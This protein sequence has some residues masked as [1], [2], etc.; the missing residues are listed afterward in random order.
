MK[1]L[2]EK[3]L[4]KGWRRTTALALLVGALALTGATVASAYGFAGHAKQRVVAAEGAKGHRWTGPQGW[5]KGWP[6]RVPSATPTPSAPPVAA[7]PA[8]TP[9]PAPPA[10]A[11]PESSPTSSAPP[12]GGDTAPV[13]WPDASSTGVPAG[14]PLTPSGGMTITR[15]GTV[16][17]GLDITGDVFVRAA[18]V[19]IENTR[20]TGRIDTGDQ[21]AYP[22][23]VFRR[24][25]VVGPDDAATDGGYPGVGYGAYTCDGCSV[26][27]W[28]KGFMVNDNVTIKNSWVSDIQVFGDPGE[29]GSHNEAILSLGGR[30]ITIVGNRL[31]AGDADNVSA[32]LALYSQWSAFDA[33]L[34]QGNLFDGG[35]YC[36]YAGLG[37]AYGASNSRF[38]GN[39]FGDKYNPNCGWYGAA[40][41]YDPGNGNQWSG[42][43][44]QR[45]GALV[46]A[47]G[48]E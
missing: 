47:P 27:G 3:V 43:V 37:G 11:G 17:N 42:N 41:A 6:G 20:V 21:G 16:I 14:T 19:T 44:L 30:N 48:R 28:G 40:V 10:S 4:R 22:N 5:S 35:G 46:P 25:D 9:A 29:G 24:V 23:A 38:L 45:T 36:L 32:S 12:S 26:R 33:V 18:N 2:V 39:T 7:T 15:P 31:D 8:P 1:K 34:V 13:G